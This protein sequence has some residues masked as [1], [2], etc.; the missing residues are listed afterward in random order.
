MSDF[1]LTKNL[2]NFL[3]ILISLFQTPIKFI[4][5]KW[6]VALSGVGVTDINFSREFVLSE[7]LH[8]DFAAPFLIVAVLVI[9]LITRRQI[10]LYKNIYLLI[11]IQLI[12]LATVVEWQPWINRFTTTVIMIGTIPLGF[13]LY[14]L[15]K[16]LAL[17][18]L[19]LII[20]YSSFWLFFNPTRTLLD[21]IMLEPIATRIGIDS[22]DLLMMRH[23]LIY[24]RDE[25]FFSAR[26]ELANSYQN[27]IKIIEREQPEI[28]SLYL[29][30][31]D[32][33]YPLWALT[34]YDL[35]LFHTEV[36][37]FDRPG[38]IIICTK[39]CNNTT[40]QTLYVDENLVL[41]SGNEN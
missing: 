6:E 36:I 33:E 34:K 30:D 27:A 40:Y 8:A 41:Y 26:P 29:G 17:F 19:S 11:L 32:F 9:S 13:Y 14:N 24:T 35:D 5:D 12:L 18:T 1:S 25:Q 7:N 22:N 37:R 38:G 16:L 21:P 31:D 23:D 4:N 39:N 10:K 3:Y 20:G 28:L 2:I 15:K